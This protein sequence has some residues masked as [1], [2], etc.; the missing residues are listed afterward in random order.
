MQIRK[1]IKKEKSRK[2]V[3]L[4]WSQ[5]GNKGHCFVRSGRGSRI[6]GSIA[7]I[8]PQHLIFVKKEGDAAEE[9]ERGRG[10]GEGRKG[11]RGKRG[12]TK[13]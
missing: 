8:H 12:A 4:S 3:I 6:S 2:K 13:E 9:R 1:K 7:G 10:K 5:T 11:G